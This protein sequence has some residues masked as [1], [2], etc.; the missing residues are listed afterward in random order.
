MDPAEHNPDASINETTTSDLKLSTKKSIHFE[1][2]NVTNDENQLNPSISDPA[3]E[4]TEEDIFR[5]KSMSID[6]NGWK[7]GPLASELQS[8]VSQV[9][10]TSNYIEEEE[11]HLEEDEEGAPPD[12][13]YEESAK[14]SG[15]TDRVLIFDGYAFGKKSPTENKSELQL[16]VDTVNLLEYPFD[17]IIPEGN[18]QEEYRQAFAQARVYLV[19]TAHFSKE[20]CEDVRK[21][22]EATQPDFVMVELCHSRIQILSMDE[23]TLLSEAQSLTSQKMMQIIRQNGVTQG[24][25]QVLL[26][27]LSAHI[28]QKLGMAPGGEFRSAYN[29]SKNVPG[30][31]LVLGDRPLQVTLKRALCS[32]NFFQKMKFFFHLLLSLRMDI[33]QEDVERCKNKDI[34]EE[35][36]EEM[37]GEYPQVS[38]ILVDERD[39][40]MAQVLHQLL[41]RG[42]MEKMCASKKLERKFEPV[43]V[44]GV[45]GMGHMKGIRANWTRHIDSSALMTIPAPSLTGR[46]VSTGFRLVFYGGFTALGVWLGYRTVVKLV[47]RFGGR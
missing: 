7:N 28:T 1:A 31:Q 19:G 5:M 21:A 8:A 46:I 44:V 34:L 35:L 17:P 32:L 29:E 20:S 24:L 10:S 43:T 2:D 22:V 3:T 36:L 6:Q 42:T 4:L 15:D 9:D 39:Q 23:E 40:Y 14:N 33:K 27:S 41:Q 16:N 13:T 11:R 25:M 47:D 30:C 18:D 12:E 26:L 38:R 45:V 37:A